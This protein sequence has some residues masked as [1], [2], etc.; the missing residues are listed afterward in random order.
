MASGRCSLPAWNRERLIG[1]FQRIDCSTRGEAE[2][3]V[4][5]FERAFRRAS[6]IA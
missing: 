6:T 5:D 3:Q 1:Q 2:R 4:A